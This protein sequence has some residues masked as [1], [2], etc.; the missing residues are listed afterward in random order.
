[1]WD[2]LRAFPDDVRESEFFIEE[3]NRAHDEWLLLDEHSRMM[4]VGWVRQR[5]RLKRQDGG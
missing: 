4:V 5:E 2:W 3:V 1:M